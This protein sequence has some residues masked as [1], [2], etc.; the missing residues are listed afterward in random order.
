MVIGEK[1]DL[2]EYGHFSDPAG[3]WLIV[4]VWLF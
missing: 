2:Y 1:N 4:R 3:D